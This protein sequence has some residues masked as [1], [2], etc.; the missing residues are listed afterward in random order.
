MPIPEDDD[1]DGPRSEMAGC[2][3][4]LCFIGLIPG[5]VFLLKWRVGV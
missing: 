2:F 4:V 1:E 5:M 3:V